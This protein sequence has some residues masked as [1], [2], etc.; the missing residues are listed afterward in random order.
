MMLP[1]RHVFF[2]SLALSFAVLSIPAHSRAA[3]LG[4]SS[5]AGE[6]GRDHK[7]SE[8][9]RLQLEEQSLMRAIETS[10]DAFETFCMP[11]PLLGVVHSN[12]PPG[13][14]PKAFTYVRSAITNTEPLAPNYDPYPEIYYLRSTAPGVFNWTVISNTSGCWDYQ[15]NMDMPNGLGTV[16]SGP[17]VDCGTYSW[18]KV[19]WVWDILGYCLWFPEGIWTSRFS[20]DGHQ[21]AALNWTFRFELD[22]QPYKTDDSSHTMCTGV[23]D[24]PYEPVNPGTTSY[25]S[26]DALAVS[27]VRLDGLAEAVDIKWE[28]IDPNGGLYFSYPMTL[29]DPGQ[30]KWWD[31]YKQTAWL[32]IAGYPAASMPG[33]WRVNF[34]TKDCAGV[35][36]FQFSDT[37]QIE[38]SLAAI[39]L[40]SP[41]N[42]ATLTS[43]PTFT[44]TANGGA[45]NVY[46]VD[47]SLTPGFT[48]YWSTYNNM[49]LLIRDTR[50]TMSLSVWNK[51][52]TGTPIYWRVRGVDMAA[53]PRPLIK[54]AQT[55]SFT[56]Q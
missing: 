56:K 21:Y 14:G 42:L 37:F 1:N 54:S 45:D 7:L 35:W 4:G 8:A 17:G 26:T 20:V 34:Y 43:P 19:W 33:T 13:I 23:N 49:R 2:V 15:V 9:D 16:Y 50:W 12:E 25:K 6:L 30:N 22:D 10:I 29:P 44:W 55:W 38:G 18:F 48:K 39:N 28:W 52:P 40:Q 36:Q 31:W 5:G 46:A 32:G 24:Y 11:E 53:S 47:A 3:D 27:W 51:I 41:A